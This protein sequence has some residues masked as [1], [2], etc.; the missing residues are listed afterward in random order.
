[1][2]SKSCF[3]FLFAIF[4]LSCHSGQRG[5]PAQ[6]GVS[7]NMASTELGR[8]SGHFSKGLITLV[9]NYIS[10]NTASGYEVHKGLRRNLN[11]QV[12]QKGGSL[13]FVLKEPGGNPFDGTF[14]ITLDSVTKKITG[15][16]VPVDSVKAHTHT[17]PV[18]LARVEESKQGDDDYGD[19]WES[20]I[21]YLNFYKDGTCTL[22][23]YP[24]EADNAQEKTVR[25]S[26]EHKADIFFIEWQNNDHTPA[27]KMKVVKM[28]ALYDKDS[29]M[30]EPPYLQGNGIKF[31]KNTAG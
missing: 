16:W 28:P 29:S 22:E 2:R 5:D 13:V 14:F 31:T 6:Q 9:I 30:L 15:T 25:G 7:D 1:M 23:Y 26:Y 21:G 11:G 18:E 17:G 24:S 20:D 8:Y 19:E 3:L 4:A 10:G 12:E 27:L